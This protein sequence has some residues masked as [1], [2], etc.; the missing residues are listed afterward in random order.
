MLELLETLFVIL[1]MV[2]MTFIT[3]MAVHMTEER[4]RGKTIPL[5]WEK[6]YKFR[7]FNKDNVKYRDGDNT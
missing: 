7:F 4:K 5:P 1:L 6:G 2:F 3:F